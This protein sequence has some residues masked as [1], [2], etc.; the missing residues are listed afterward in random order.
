MRTYF[1]CEAKSE[2]AFEPKADGSLLTVGK[3]KNLPFARNASNK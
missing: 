3:A 2:F 1:F